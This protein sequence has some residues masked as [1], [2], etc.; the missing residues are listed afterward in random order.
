MRTAL[1]VS[2]ATIALLVAVL[3]LRAAV[4][5]Q[6]ATAHAEVIFR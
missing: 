1:V 3:G 6:P 4:V 2:I 5:S